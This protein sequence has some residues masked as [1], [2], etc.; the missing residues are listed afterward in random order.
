[1]VGTAANCLPCGLGVTCGASCS[2]VIHYMFTLLNGSRSQLSLLKLLAESSVALRHCAVALWHCAIAPP[3]GEAPGLVPLWLINS[4]VI[5]LRSLHTYSYYLLSG[6][7]DS[8]FLSRHGNSGLFL[9]QWLVHCYVLDTSINCNIV[10][11]SPAFT[12]KIQV[13]Y[14]Q[15]IKNTKYFQYHAKSVIQVR[16]V[17]IVTHLAIFL[18]YS[19]NHSYPGHLLAAPPW[20]QQDSAKYRLLYKK[21]HNIISFQSSNPSI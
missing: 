10:A 14:C 16:N 6:H 9:W 13:L 1:M 19:R 8:H 5:W 11:N 20:V 18:L 21:N 4:I 2:L 12:P 17:I 3:F 7:E 15:K